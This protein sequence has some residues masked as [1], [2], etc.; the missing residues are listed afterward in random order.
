MVRQRAIRTGRGSWGHATNNDLPGEAL[1]EGMPA[2]PREGFHLAG[3]YSSS[4][5]LRSA[6]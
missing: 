5:F 4:L 6:I 3:R 1:D 2:C